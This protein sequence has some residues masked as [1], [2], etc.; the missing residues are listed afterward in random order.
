MICGEGKVVEKEVK[1]YETNVAGTKM[2][3]P[4]AIVGTCDSCGV[5]NYA[6]RKD[7]WL[8]AQEQGNPLD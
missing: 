2:T 8:K 3:L 1:N 4:E 7:A 5:V 6:F